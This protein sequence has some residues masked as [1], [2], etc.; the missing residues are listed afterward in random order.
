MADAQIASSLGAT[1]RRTHP[2][3]VHRVRDM[4]A[5]VSAATMIAA[6]EG[7][8]DRADAT[9]WLGTIDVPVLLI[10]AAPSV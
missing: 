10:A 5:T 1:T 8:R 2:A 4:M 7:M 9:A 3:L 6:Q